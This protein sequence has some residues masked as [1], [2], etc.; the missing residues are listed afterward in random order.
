MATSPVCHSG[1]PDDKA[2]KV[3]HF[4]NGAQAYKSIFDS[5]VRG[6]AKAEAYLHIEV[7]TVEAGC[8]STT[9]KGG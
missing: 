2:L 8:N 6:I 4:I 7:T 9:W 1:H 3:K 5:A